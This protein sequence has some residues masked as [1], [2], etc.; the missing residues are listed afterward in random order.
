[1]SRYLVVA[2]VACQDEDDILTN[3]YQVGVYDSV[4][5]AIEEARFD[6]R[7]EIMNDRSDFYDPEDEEGRVNLEDDVSE[8]MGWARVNSYLTESDFAR[9]FAD[10][11]VISWKSRDYA[12]VQR[13]L[14]TVIRID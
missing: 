6:L 8:K 5:E 13:Y 4:S 9:P 1:M 3:N 12:N 2:S 10:R 11:H 7:G 14:Y